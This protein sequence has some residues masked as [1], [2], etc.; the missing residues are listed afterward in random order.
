MKS[1]RELVST[2]NCENLFECIFGLNSMDMRV[3]TVLSELGN[4]RVEDISRTLG[5]RGATVYK[6]LQ[7]LVMVGL[8]Y[9]EKRVFDG[10]GYC[11]VYKPVPKADVIREVTRIVDEFCRRVKEIA[12]EFENDSSSRLPRMWNV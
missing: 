5:K 7:K 11:F 1:V 9:R 4:G 8:V 12:G 6:S 3:Y 10:G 2:L